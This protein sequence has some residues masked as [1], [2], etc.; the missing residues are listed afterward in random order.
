MS[1]VLHAIFHIT[2]APNMTRHVIP[3]SGS[4]GAKCIMFML[5]DIFCC[6]I[7]LLSIYLA[8]TSTHFQ[9]KGPKLQSFR[10]FK[11]TNTSLS[12]IRHSTNKMCYISGLWN[13]LLF[14]VLMYAVSCHMKALTSSNLKKR[15]RF[16]G[17][18]TKRVLKSPIAALQSESSSAESRLIKRHE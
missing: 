10:S 1:L 17:G 16:F 14:I 5:R 6:Y 13:V 2:A 15:S 18:Q 4:W 11:Q 12:S 8:L 7:F 9:K 3:H